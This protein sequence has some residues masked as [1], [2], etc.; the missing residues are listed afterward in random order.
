M[1]TGGTKDIVVD[2]ETGLLSSNAGELGDDIGRLQA[3]VALRQRRGRNARVK[4][5]QTFESGV[6]IDR[7]ERL[8]RE[9]EGRHRR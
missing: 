2:E 1:D 8:Y 3:D 9:L 7:I 5:E 4:V 6:V